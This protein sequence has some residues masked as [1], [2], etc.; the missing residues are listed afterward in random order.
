MK[1][2]YEPF[3]NYTELLETLNKR[4]N[5]SVMRNQ[6]SS[7]RNDPEWFGTKNYEEAEKMVASGFPEAVNA[8]KRNVEAQTKINS[9]FYNNVN[10]AMPH[11]AV[12]GYIPNVPNALQ[13]LPQSMISIDHKPM[14]RK[15]LHIL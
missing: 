12:V 11:N 9:K 5:N 10:H 7:H 1:V 15:T 6:H 14:K 4:P 8:L 3:R 13:N 2:L